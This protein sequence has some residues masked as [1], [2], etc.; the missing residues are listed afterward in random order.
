MLTEGLDIL[1]HLLYTIV[2]LRYKAHDRYNQR[3]RATKY[4]GSGT[5]NGS[6]RIQP[7]GSLLPH[8]AA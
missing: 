6:R 1:L 5:P 8:A 4:V 2:T 7:Q 3:A